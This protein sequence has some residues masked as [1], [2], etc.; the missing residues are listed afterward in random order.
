MDKFRT[1]RQKF[2]KS[3]REESNLRGLKITRG[4]EEDDFSENLWM[5]LYERVL[6]AAELKPVNLAVF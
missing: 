4:I 1:W 2:I 3:S 6:R 5:W